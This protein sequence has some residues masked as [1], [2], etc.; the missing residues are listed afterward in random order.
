ML[1]GA[2][3][4]QLSALGLGAS[5][6]IGAWSFAAVVADEFCVR[7]DA[8]AI[9]SRAIMLIAILIF[10]GSDAATMLAGI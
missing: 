5:L 9:A 8:G 7:V 4:F 1:L 6:V 3:S 2:F 10:H